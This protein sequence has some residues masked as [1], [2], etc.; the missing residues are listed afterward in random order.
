VLSPRHNELAS[1]VEKLLLVRSF[2]LLDRT[3]SFPTFLAH[4]HEEGLCGCVLYAS[5]CAAFLPFPARFVDLLLLYLELWCELA[6]G[7][8][9][10]SCGWVCLSTAA[11][12]ASMKSFPV[13]SS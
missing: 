1:V 10:W 6:F 9:G 4:L 3:G 11:I 5:A 2:G 12:V 8:R 7:V 13:W